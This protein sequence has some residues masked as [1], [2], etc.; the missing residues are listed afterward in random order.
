[1]IDLMPATDP[2]AI[3]YVGITNATEEDVPLGIAITAVMQMKAL[4][5]VGPRPRLERDLRIERRQ[6]RRDRSDS[7]PG[8]Q[9]SLGPRDARLMDARSG[10][11]VTLRPPPAPPGAQQVGAQRP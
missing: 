1:M 8:C 4:A 9:A 3:T 7:H 5:P 10:L 2:G 6:Q 11:Q